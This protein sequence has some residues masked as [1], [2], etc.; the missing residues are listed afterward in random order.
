MEKEQGKKPATREKKERGPE[1]CSTEILLLCKAWISASEDAVV[2]VNQKLKTF[3]SKIE[4]AYNVFKQQHD[5]YMEKE[6]QNDNLRMQ[7]LHR[8]L[9]AD[10]SM[11]LR[12]NNPAGN[13]VVMQQKW[14]KHV[15]RVIPKFIDVTSRYPKKSGEDNDEY[16]ARIHLI[17]LK[18]NPSE[19]SFDV[20][21]PSYEY[22]CTKPK[23]SMACSTLPGKRK[24][25]I[26]LD[27]DVIKRT[28]IGFGHLEETKPKGRWKMIKFLLLLQRSCS[29][30]R[31]VLRR[32]RSK[33]NS[34][35]K[36]YL[37]Q[38]SRFVIGGKYSNV[39]DIALLISSRSTTIQ[40]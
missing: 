16:Y 18:E 8:V 32:W 21:W 33:C 35:L 14:D 29:K 17:Y 13:A 38:F 23:F 3:W 2:G 15:K 1:F 39:F 10:T 4:D 27:D 34:V 12:E 20:Y 31:Q 6:Q 9:G 36:K 28:M 5:S 11:L 37:L 40:W 30:H 26:S 24:E 7:Q 22:L 19:K 25:V